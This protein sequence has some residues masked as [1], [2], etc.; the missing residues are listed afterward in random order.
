MYE[1]HTHTETS[2]YIQTVCCPLSIS[3]LT[4]LNSFVLLLY[5]LHLDSISY[6]VMCRKQCFSD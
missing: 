3:S 1:K 2:L 4:P 5:H 6:Q